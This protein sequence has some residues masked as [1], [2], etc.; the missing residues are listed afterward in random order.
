MQKAIV[1]LLGIIAI[2]LLVLVLR[3]NG[4][5]R[6]SE[7]AT[8]KDEKH[9]QSRYGELAIQGD[10]NDME[11]RWKSGRLYKGEGFSLSFEAIFSLGDEDAILVMENSGGTACPA[12]YFF[13][14]I[15]ED[16]NA[17][18]LKQFGTCSDLDVSKQEGSVV[19]VS[20]PGFRGPFESDE[21]KQ[22]AASET[23]VFTLSKGEVTE[24]VVT[25]KSQ[26]S[27]ASRQ[28]NSNGELPDC[29]DRDAIA[30]VKSTLEK[31]NME[32]FEIDGVRDISS[33]PIAK[34]TQVMTGKVLTTCSAT[35]MAD[36]GEFSIV[37]EFK[38]LKDGDTIVAVF[39]S[40]E[41]QKLA[42]QRALEFINS[43]GLCKLHPDAPVCR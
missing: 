37:Y 5:G 3:G 13:V 18:T 41:Y 25:D 20:L 38:T 42:N 16:G 22:K 29:E 35:V 39:T 12:L 32:V 31:N 36:K 1:A 24:R 9:V 19:S 28:A 43:G 40:A 17:R 27:Q 2:L 8:L 34:T 6:V 26:G 30:T 11:I 14:L 4:S 21:E 7:S 10:T 33:E 23:H 15:G